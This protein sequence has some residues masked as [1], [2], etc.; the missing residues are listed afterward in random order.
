MRQLRMLHF[1]LILGPVMALAIL[2]FLRSTQPV[3]EGSVPSVVPF[4]LL[5]FSGMLILTGAV[6]RTRIPPLE[7]GADPDRWAE[8]QKTACVALWA[9]LEA[10]VLLCAVAIFL[11]ADP[12]IAGALAAGG[13]GFLASQS[14][15]AVAGH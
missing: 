1:P 11:G 5:G 9:T 4:I 7:A 14:P 12:W 15:G 13:L 8:Q 3:A 10:S 6:M 2:A